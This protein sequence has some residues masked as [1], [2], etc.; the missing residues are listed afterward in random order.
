[1][2]RASRVANGTDGGKKNKRKKT[3]TVFEVSQIAVKKGIKKCLQLVALA[4]Q[5][6]RE[7]KTDLAKFIANRGA[8][9]VEEALS[10]GW[11]MEKAELDLAR[12]KLSLVDLIVLQN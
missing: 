4:S 8:K 11:E 6:K 2:F 12:S 7:G 10:V 1:M 3:L 9:A 5:Q